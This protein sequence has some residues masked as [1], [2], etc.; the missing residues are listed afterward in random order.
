M[1]RFRT[2]ALTAGA[3]LAAALPLAAPSARADGASASA[4]RGV[5]QAPGHPLVLFPGREGT[6]A[7]FCPDGTTPTGGGA[8]VE[9]DLRSPV[10]VRRSEL[11]PTA[12]GWRVM[13]YNASPDVQTVHPHVVCS[14]DSSLTVQNG[15]EVALDPG[16]PVSGIASCDNTKF[17]V[18]GGF[19]AGTSTFAEDS[20]SGDIRS[21]STAAKYTD[22]D[23]AA[24]PSYLRTSVICSD[25]QPSWQPSL[26][27][28]L[29]PGT[30]GT[31]HAECPGGQVPLSG[32][33]TA[34]DNAF[35]T[36]SIPTATGWTV[37]A[38]NTGQDE[39][40][41]LATVLCTAP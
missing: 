28:K 24:P 32:G 30:A 16:E 19:D 27:V 10:F 31:T 18:G 12:N 34:G 25:A 35:L 40:T 29:A 15:N 4:P 41:L 39:R 20:S 33:G 6:V 13:V 26:I 38:M 37:W 14:T 23:P 2:T 7:A 22:Y 21:W 3:F 8:T 1:R 9:S 36:S 17:A 5:V 11:H